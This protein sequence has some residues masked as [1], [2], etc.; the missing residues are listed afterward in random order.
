MKL[1][2]IIGTIV[3]VM[4]VVLMLLS[5]GYGFLRDLF[6]TR[7]VQILRTPNDAHKAVLKRLDGIDLVFFV[8]VDGQKVYSSPDF[9]PNH[10]VNFR[11]RITWDKT[12]SILIL[13]VTDRRLFGYNADTQ[14][15]LS[16]IELMSVEYAT[17]PNEW[18]Y[19]FEGIWPD[20]RINR[21]KHQH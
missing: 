8:I 18:E 20:E 5:L 4:A 7:T 3:I 15:V 13:E 1:R 6:P 19:G 2:E 11:E 16:N 10:K 17:E 14:K 12:G 21:E 9:A